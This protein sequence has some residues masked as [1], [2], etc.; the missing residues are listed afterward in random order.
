MTRGQK[1][2]K[3]LQI[4]YQDLIQMARRENHY[5][6]SMLEKY[7]FEPQEIASLNVQIEANKSDIAYYLEILAKT[8]AENEDH[9]TEK[10]ESPTEGLVA[11]TCTTVL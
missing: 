11:V 2:L 5:L 6:N 8:G 3:L 4:E 10:S 1:Y 9:L 7:M